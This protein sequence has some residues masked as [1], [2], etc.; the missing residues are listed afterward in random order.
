MEQAAVVRYIYTY[1]VLV[2]QVVEAAP[3]CWRGALDCTTMCL[4]WLAVS[5][6]C[7]LETAACTLRLEEGGHVVSALSRLLEQ[8][9]GPGAA[10]QQLPISSRPVATALQ[11]QPCSNNP[12]AAAAAYQQQPSS[13]SPAESMIEAE[14]CDDDY[15]SF[16]QPQ[17]SPLRQPQS[18]EQQ[19]ATNTQRQ[20]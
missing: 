9:S 16:M 18:V 3:F 19:S 7:A 8:Q 17:G 11:Q 14:A 20:L 15:M 13:S 12:A 1:S 4:E 5:N 2:E 6:D 10:Q